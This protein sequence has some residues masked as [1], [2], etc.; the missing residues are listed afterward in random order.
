MNL[1]FILLFYIQ[2]VNGLIYY[3]TQSNTRKC[4]YH[5]LHK[6]TILTGK[7]KLEIFDEITQSYRPPIDRVEIGVVIDVEEV[8]NSNSRVVHQ[9]GVA[10]GQFSFN[11]LET[12]QHRIC[13]TPKSFIGGGGGGLWFGNNGNNGNGGQHHQDVLKDSRFKLARIGI[14]LMNTDPKLL[15]SSRKGEMNSIK[16]QIYRLHGKLH[17]IRREQVLIR[18][19]EA[20]FRDLSERTC[21][22]VL[23]GVSIQLGALFIILLYQ[24]YSYSK[25]FYN[26]KQKL[27]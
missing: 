3:Y 11:T 4:F 12:G 14:Q 26:N 13:L 7:Y 23:R 18:E 15:D 10:M 5:E 6:E 20:V 8:F 24:L 17:E 21:D 16:R 9:R 2:I 19:K 1:R 25:S 22:T 27:E